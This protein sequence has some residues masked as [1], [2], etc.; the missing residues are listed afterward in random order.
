MALQFKHFFRS[1]KWLVYI[2]IAYP[3]V[4]LSDRLLVPIL[5]E[6]WTI[7]FSTIS[8]FTNAVAFYVSG[9]VSLNRVMNSSTTVAYMQV[10]IKSSQIK[11]ADFLIISLITIWFVVPHLFY[12]IAPFS[13]QFMENFT[14]IM[15]NI[16]NSLLYSLVLTTTCFMLIY[17]PLVINFKNKITI[18]SLFSFIASIAVLIYWNRYDF[19]TFFMGGLKSR[20]FT[21]SNVTSVPDLFLIPFPQ[22]WF[23]ALSLTITFVVICIIYVYVF[24][25]YYDIYS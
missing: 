14:L 9:I 23:I 2:L 1:L 22:A 7:Y 13:V 5:S 19:A 25:A 15:L 12:E 16:Y 24:S 18:L 21:Y 6:S 10:P 4:S 11:L 17:L 8:L 20:F 3:V